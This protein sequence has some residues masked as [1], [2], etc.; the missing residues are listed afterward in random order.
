ME[1]D[2][3]R[4]EWVPIT[5]PA[6]PV[7]NLAFPNSNTVAS[8]TYVETPTFASNMREHD[9]IP[10]F[11]DDPRIQAMLAAPGAML[12]ALWNDDVGPNASVDAP[13]TH[14]QS[15]P[16][17]DAPLQ[18]EQYQ[19]PYADQHIP[20]VDMFY[21]F[22]DTTNN[23]AANEPAPEF[24]AGAIP[25][26]WQQ[27]SSF[28]SDDQGRNNTPP[29]PVV[30]HQNR[31]PSIFGSNNAGWQESVAVPL[32]AS[33]PMEHSAAFLDASQYNVTIDIP[34]ELAMPGS[35]NPVSSFVRRLHPCWNLNGTLL[36]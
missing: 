3:D 29:F 1:Y 18:N 11:M 4:G 9:P 25:L 28:V 10:N 24:N 32:N 15:H 36:S 6:N 16:T 35:M 5:Y 20:P 34:F 23:P 27:P 7:P 21:Q 26:Q 12:D 33:Y 22:Q 31:G 17:F 2:E 13:T 8:A 30:E 14:F 19:A